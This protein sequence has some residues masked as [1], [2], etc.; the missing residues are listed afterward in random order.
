[1][2]TAARRFLM[3]LALLASTFLRRSTSQ[4]AGNIRGFARKSAGVT[5]ALAREKAL[6]QPDWSKAEELQSVKVGEVQ[7]QGTFEHYIVP[8]QE[9]QVWD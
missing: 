3:P 1:M 7:S 5:A 6:Q 9:E 8:K 4:S 2:E